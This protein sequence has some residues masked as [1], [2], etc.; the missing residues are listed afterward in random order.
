MWWMC[1]ARTAQLLICMY[2]APC[3]C[4]LTCYIQ[5]LLVIEGDTKPVSLESRFARQSGCAVLCAS[6]NGP[7]WKNEGMGGEKQ[8]RRGWEWWKRGRWICDWQE[9]GKESDRQHRVA[10]FQEELSSFLAIF[11]KEDVWNTVLFWSSGP[12]SPVKMSCIPASHR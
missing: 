5:A 6:L 9:E 8:R 1:T 4:T 2:E 11:V 7:L 3:F 12:L 10:D